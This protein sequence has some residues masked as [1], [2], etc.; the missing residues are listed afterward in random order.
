MKSFRIRLMRRADADINE[1]NE[2]EDAADLMFRQPVRHY[3]KER[4]AGMILSASAGSFRSN[5]L[6]AGRE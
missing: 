2:Q 5:M 3:R 6:Y 1:G 4:Q